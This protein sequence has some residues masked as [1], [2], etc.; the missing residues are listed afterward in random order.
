MKSWNRSKRRAGP[1]SAT[2][3]TA[4]TVVCLRIDKKLFTQLLG[5]LHDEL[6]EHM[7]R[8]VKRPASA[9]RSDRTD[10][11]QSADAT[12]ASQTTEPLAEHHVSLRH[13]ADVASRD[14]RCNLEKRRVG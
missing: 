9:G 4:S 1:R 14:I 12:A 13:H 7:P 8:D 3:T 10:R 11:P 5:S 2:V 6:G